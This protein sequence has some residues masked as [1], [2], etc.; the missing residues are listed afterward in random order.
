MKN[1]GS[2]P[3]AC[4]ANEDG[5]L[6]SADLHCIRRLSQAQSCVPANWDAR[7][8]TNLNAIVDFS[9][10]YSFI[11][12]FKSSRFWTTRLDWGDWGTNQPE[13]LDL[14][15][16]GYVH[17]LPTG[18]NPPYRYV[19]TFLFKD[20][21]GNYPSGV[22]H[23][24]YEGEGTIG[25]GGDATVDWPASSA[26]HHVL[27]VTP[28]NSGIEL[29]ISQTDPNQTGNYIRN[30]RILHEDFSLGDETSAIFHPDFL[31]SIR[32]FKALRFMDWMRTNFSTQGMRSDDGFAVNLVDPEGSLTPYATLVNGHVVNTG[33]P[34]DT[35]AITER[36]SV[37]DAQYST[38]KGAP[39][40]VMVAL[41][42]QVN[43]D[44]WFNMPHLATDDYVTDFATYV[45]DNLEPS[46]RVY[47]E[48]SNEIWNS[49]FTQY[50]WI[51]DQG[52]AEWPASGAIDSGQ[53]VKLVWQT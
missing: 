24:Y 45:R 19:S 53:A 13:L 23:V 7:L 36:P 49:V 2:Y 8:G 15:E 10:E 52:K 14:D 1:D 35:R 44:P 11:N 33:D 21:D 28:S 31:D 32:P 25:Y 3:A 46:Q 39:V 51:T 17:T 22:Y 26:G 43:S 42:N 16:N 27:N 47:V 29:T 48:Y 6:T 18:S 34:D 30:I 12:A 4:D 41:A 37:N 20:I 9:P 38:D 50:W 40:E 5:S